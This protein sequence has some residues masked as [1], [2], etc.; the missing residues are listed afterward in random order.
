MKYIFFAI[1]IVGFAFLYLL[2]KFDL[3]PS[4]K[5]KYFDLEEDEDEVIF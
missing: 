5:D 3:K 2:L 4:E 1:L